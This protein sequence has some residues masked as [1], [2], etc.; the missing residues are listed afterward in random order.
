MDD[1][2]PAALLATLL[3]G[4]GRFPAGA[5]AHSLGLEAAVNADLVRDLDDLTRWL[6]GQLHTTWTVDVA[7]ALH[8]HA[9][10]GSAAPAEAWRRLDGEVTARTTSPE[11]RAVSRQLGRQLLRAA[12]RA[13]PSAALAELQDLHP[14]GPHVAVVQ[15]A[16]GAAAG[17]DAGAT[18]A[19]VLHGA[20]QLATSAAVRLLG[21]DPYAVVGMLADLGPVLASVAT[22]SVAA[23]GDDPRRLPAVGAPATDLL[24][25]RHA[26]A[27]GRLFAS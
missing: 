6:D 20:A 9:L 18:A 15:G 16:A 14:D 11:L 10:A 22:V 7:V 19:V 17:L 26:T 27:D 21:L 3:L 12:T 5:H 8:A 4:D 13:W 24:L 25:A 1:P 23:V 2:G